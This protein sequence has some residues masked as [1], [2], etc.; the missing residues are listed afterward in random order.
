VRKH[1][2]LLESAREI[3]VMVYQYRNNN[4]CTYYSNWWETKRIGS[5]GIGWDRL[6]Q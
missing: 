3:I 5:D 2:N 1:G 4:D 6:G